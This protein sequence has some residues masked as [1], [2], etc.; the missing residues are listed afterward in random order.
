[1]V[2]PMTT[3]Q[4]TPAAQEAERT[5]TWTPPSW[6]RRTQR[7]TEEE[8]AALVDFARKHNLPI[9]DAVRQLVAEGIDRDKQ[10]SQR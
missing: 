10:H 5:R 4:P 6:T 2:S 1:M 3:P 9:N 8:D 7:F